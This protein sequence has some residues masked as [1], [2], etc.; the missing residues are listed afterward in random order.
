M[1]EEK[2][3]TKDFTVPEKKRRG[4]PKGSYKKTGSG[5]TGGTRRGRKK[6]ISSVN[7]LSSLINN[8]AVSY[9]HLTLPT[10]LLV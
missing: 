10:I 6:K 8:R 2:G 1:T 7:D 9:T 4:R 5:P 3:E